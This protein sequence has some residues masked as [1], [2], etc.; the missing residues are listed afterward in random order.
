MSMLQP[1]VDQSPMV[2]RRLGFAVL[3]FGCLIVRMLFQALDMLSDVSHIDEC[4]PPSGRSPVRRGGLATLF[5]DEG[6]TA[7]I[8]KWTLA[9]VV[10]VCAWACLVALK[11]LIGINLRAYAAMRFATREERTQEDALNGRGRKPIGV[12]QEET[13]QDRRMLE[14]IDGAEF[15]A[16]TKPAPGVKI[17]MEE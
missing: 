14:M 4:A 11:L 3:P 13:A 15:D 12:A 6:V 17:A 8:A 5:L 16:P 9:G 10:T 1:F 2:S 7:A